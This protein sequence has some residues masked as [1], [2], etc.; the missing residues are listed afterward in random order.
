M[1][2]GSRRAQLHP[3]LAISLGSIG[4]LI[5]DELAEEAKEKKEVKK[6]KKKELHR[7][8]NNLQ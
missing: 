5:H 8:Q 6:K 1:E 2:F 3:E 4:A 7:C